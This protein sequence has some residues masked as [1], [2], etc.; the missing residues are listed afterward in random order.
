MS[1]YQIDALSLLKHDYTHLPM[2]FEHP[3][4]EL[5]TTKDINH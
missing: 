3:G 2:R 1:T 4:C 5:A